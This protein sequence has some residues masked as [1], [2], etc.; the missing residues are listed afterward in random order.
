M[1]I[2]YLQTLKKVN[3]AF[4][5]ALF[6][7]IL[8]V[9]ASVVL[10]SE[11]SDGSKTIS[12]AEIVQEPSLSQAEL[13]ALAAQNTTYS[14]TEIDRVI[15]ES[16]WGPVEIDQNVGDFELNDGGPM[17][18]NDV[19]FDKGFGVHATSILSFD[20]EEKCSTF[21]TSYGVD[22]AN[23]IWMGSV[24]FKVYADGNLIHQSP[25]YSSGTEVGSTG[26]LSMSGVDE[27]MLIVTDL[28]G[29]HFQDWANWGY[30]EV[31]CSSK[32]GGDGSSFRHIRGDWEPVMDWPVKA[33]HATLLP[34][35]HIVSHASV[36]P[37]AIAPGDPNLDHDY[38]RVDVSN[39][40][41]W[42]HQWADHTSQE[43]Y[44]SAHTLLSDG[45]LFEFGGHDGDHPGGKVFGKT[46]ASKFNFQSKTWE[47][48]THMS[49]ARWYP[50]A[51]TL[52]NGDILAIGGSNG[53]DNIYKPEV[54]DGTNWRT[55][56][57]IDYSNLLITNNNVF[58]H[59]YPFV[60]LVSDGRVFWAGWDKK[61]AYI[62]TTGNGSWGQFYT[63]EDKHRAWGSPVMYEQD[64]LLLIGGVQSE[65]VYGTAAHSTMKIDLTGNTPSTSLS[66]DM[67]FAR[68]DADGT[69]LANGEV[70][71]NGGGY[72]HFLGY[73]PT[74]IFTPEIWNPETEEWTIGDAATN[75]R[76]Y[77][78]STL[79]LP[80]ATVWTAGGECG[81]ECTLGQSAQIYNPPYLYKKDGSGEFAPR[82]VINS[83]DAKITYGEQFD[84]TVNAPKGI[85]KI[86]FIRYGSSTHHI[87]F[88]Q[89]I[90]VLDYTKNGNNLKIT[91]P[92]NGNL[93]PP[94][95]Y[96][97]FVIDNDGVP[98]VAKTIQILPDASA[99]QPTPTP[100]TPEPTPQ[101]ETQWIPVSSSDNST[102]FA[103]HEAAYV[104]LNGKFYLMGGRGERPT[105][106]FDPVAKTWTNLGNPPVKFHHFQPV[107]FGNKIY[108][109]GALIGNYPSETPVSNVYI[110]DP[111]DNSWTI[112]P[113]IPVARRRGA[114]GTVVHNGKIYVVGGNTNGHS[115]GFVK[116]VDA[117]DP[118]TGTWTTKKDAP[119]E[120][121]HFTAVV[122]GNKIYAVGGRKTDLPNPFDGEIFQVDVY[123]INTDK[124][125]TPSGG[126]PTMRAGTM[127]VGHGNDVI[128]I[129]GE[130][131]NSTTAHND[132]E[133]YNTANNSWSS[134][135]DL[136]ARRH[137]GGAVV[138]N[139][140]I[141]VAAG[142]GGQG[143]GPELSGQEKLN[144]ASN[145]VTP[146]PTLLPTTDAPSVPTAVP[147]EES[148]PTP[149]PT[150]PATGS[151]LRE[152][153]TNLP[154]HEVQHLTSNENY[155]D[156][157][158]TSEEITIFETEKDYADNYGQRLRGYIH[159]PVTGSYTFWIASDNKS[160]LWI[161]SDENPA[162]AG[163]AAYLDSA[164]A[165]RAFN[166]FEE[167]Q[168]FDIF[169]EVGKRY[170]VEALHKDLDQGD[171][172]SVAW[173]YP[174]QE[175]V[176]IEGEFLSPFTGL[177]EPTPTPTITP[178][179]MPTHTPV[180]EPTAVPGTTPEPPAGE[181]P[182]ISIS[183]VELDEGDESPTLVFTVRLSESSS[184]M[185]SVSFKTVDVDAEAGV[186]Y[187][188]K[189]GK[190]SIAAGETT[191][192]IRI[193]L[194]NDEIDEAN[195]AF[196]VVLFDPVNGHLGQ[197]SEATGTIL[198]DDGTILGPDAADIFLP[199]IGR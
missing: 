75:P 48:V 114:G 171:H 59:T 109:V 38:T 170:Y 133:V 79:L 39:I 152:V 146:T 90:Q 113:E 72:Y 151:I 88:E 42:S 89:R 77:H 22:I 66:N 131:S 58:D 71:I 195:E 26:L 153:W 9:S 126:I 92:E 178:T 156:N 111:A 110:F 120:R 136:F 74:Q 67:L 176:V 188:A 50:S 165:F 194:L 36:D 160:E 96:M 168:S 125:T 150:L 93:A 5:A 137:S 54:F 18:V 154:G 123:D 112:G 21:S 193:K 115:G 81:D 61:M 198:D 98:S 128:V 127:S 84:A 32:P 164:V 80:D 17:T 179:P 117:F 25:P 29:D 191:A 70:L 199:F 65:N 44:C 62:D 124:W 76:A 41:T 87:N 16:G 172:L 130:S 139:N 163:R 129:G 149:L 43:M 102:A 68:A 49:Q 118:L 23:G 196:K 157:P 105:E 30:P 35:G 6:I 116:W 47:E 108:V 158:T 166:R 15:S 56:N 2:Q 159:P 55:L 141:Y 167:Q 135:P 20:L 3:S 37:G 52:G 53:E 104:E 175:Q 73:N 173:A 143:G 24:R 78:S 190:L 19:V 192:A 7:L 107:A 33:I 142:S 169:M 180:V 183:D 148:T 100:T 119:T 138:W 182:A 121:D 46:Q 99:P 51:V 181:G 27:L 103:R 177:I 86:T 97:L 147:T 40:Q 144:L 187:E 134:L 4:L 11:T 132:V 155:P 186:D 94:G 91:A 28:S 13:A 189:S 63:R 69:L 82:P 174:G 10:S 12:P 8:G 45:T 197:A 64:K 85:K 60:H 31:N 34:S 185:V 140:T 145:H 101:P 106:V 57:N 95:Y 161:S 83:A 122:I 14:L 1:V 184:D 162:N